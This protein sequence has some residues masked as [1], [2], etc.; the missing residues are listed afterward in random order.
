MNIIINTFEDKK[1]ELID[2][3]DMNLKD[4]LDSAM[5]LTKWE[6]IETNSKTH[7]MLDAASYL[8]NWHELS[9]EDLDFFLQFEN[10]LEVVADAWCERCA[11]LDDMSFTLDVLHARKEDIFADYP[12]M[13]NTTAPVDTSLR[14]FMNIKLNSFLGKIAD[15]V[16]IH[17]PNDF[18]VDLNVLEKAAESQDSAAKR[19]IWHVCSYGT[20][21][22]PERDVFIKDTADHVCMTEYR[23]NDP[24]MFGYVIEVIGKDGD[25][26]MGNVYDVGNYAEYAKYIKE[27]SIP[28]ESVSFVFSDEWGENAGK[29]ITINQKD[30]DDERFDNLGESGKVKEIIYHSENKEKLATLLSVERSRRMS[31][32]I[33]SMKRHLLRI[34]IKLTDLRQMSEQVLAEPTASKTTISERLMKASEKVQEYKTQQQADNQNKL[35]SKLSM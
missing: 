9:D 34:M 28:L 15:K 21:I 14:R 29:T 17:H 1:K 13:L 16:I 26:V 32:P 22:S 27:A 8:T 10:P 6:I 23:Q 25:A 33:G 4:Y 19:F 20:H 31:Y 7:A 24:D 35:T 12:L 30:C 11:E 5:S 2:R 18:A 3:L